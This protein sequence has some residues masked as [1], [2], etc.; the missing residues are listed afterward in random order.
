MD[1]KFLVSD[2]ACEGCRHYGHFTPDLRCCCYCSDT[3]YL[4]PRGE[5]PKDCSVKTLG[6]RGE[7]LRQL[8]HSGGF[9]LEKILSYGDRP[10]TA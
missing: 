8:P 5:A 9:K 3:G 7:Y 10:K 1:N 2:V 4:S 6:D